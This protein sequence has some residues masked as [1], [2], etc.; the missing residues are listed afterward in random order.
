MVKIN[1]IYLSIVAATIFN[2]LQADSVNLGEVSVTATKSSIQTSESPASV[3]VITSEQISNKDVQRADEA[4]K[5]VAGVFVRS[6]G[7]HT[8]SS[9]SNSESLR[10][11][12]GYSRTAVLVDGVSINNAFS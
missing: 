7:D 8:P 5:D 10:G 11:M 6:K 12:S 3:E 1:G 9:W 4:L 2:T